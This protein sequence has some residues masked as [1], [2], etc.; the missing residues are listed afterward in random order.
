MRGHEPLPGAHVSEIRR[1]VITSVFVEENG[2]W[3]I[4]ALQNTDIVPILLPG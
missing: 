2:R 1:G 3:L 4:A